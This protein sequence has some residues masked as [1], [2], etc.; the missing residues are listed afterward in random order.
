M[1]LR[2][3]AA[4]CDPLLLGHAVMLVEK[5]VFAPTSCVLLTPRGTIGSR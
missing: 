2:A 1:S 3:Q 4:F 5:S